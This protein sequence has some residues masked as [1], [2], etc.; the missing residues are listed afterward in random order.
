MRYDIEAAGVKLVFEQNRRT[1]VRVE[2]A[3]NMPWD[4]IADAMEKG[5]QAIREQIVMSSF[6]YPD[7]K[8]I[9]EETLANLMESD[10]KPFSKLFEDIASAGKPQV[11]VEASSMNSDNGV[12]S[13]L[14]QETSLS[15]VTK[16]SKQSSK[17][18]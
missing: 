4:E 13:D 15:E 16:K 14:N 10:P 3:L 2:I 5:S 17:V 12:Q 1:R 9:P 11:D 18:E 7:G 6:S 8:L